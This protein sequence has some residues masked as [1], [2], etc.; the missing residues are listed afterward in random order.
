M[1]TGASSLSLAASGFYLLVICAAVI[2]MLTARRNRQQ[3]WHVRG[4]LMLA[5]LFLVL[6]IMRILDVEDLLREELRE[7]LRSQGSYGERRGFQRPLAAGVLAI[8]ALVGFWWFYR[9]ARTIRGR[10]N[11]AVTI[12]L[13]N[14]AAMVL[15]V[16]LR[17]ISLSPVD[18]LLYGPIKL[19]WIVD[20]GLGLSVVVSALAYVRI[21]GSRR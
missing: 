16:M 2:A 4:W 6:A 17:L 3:K 19:N 10:R 15:L 5:L 18:A 9:T 12:G 21:V 1:P 20:L 11:V 7:T 8:A 14:G 13:A